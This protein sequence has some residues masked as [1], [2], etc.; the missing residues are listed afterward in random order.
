MT[1]T[2]NQKRVLGI[3]GSPRRGGNTEIIVDE[4]LSGAAQAGAVVEKIIL[5]ELNIGPCRA[6]DSCYTIRKCV[7]HDDMV[8]L[9]EKMQLS[10]VWVLGT[11]VY[12]MGPTAQFKT[13]LDRWY[14]AD[15]GHIV[16]FKGKRAILAIS[17]EDRKKATAHHTIGM[18]TGALNWLKVELLATVLAPGVRAKGAVK[19]CSDILTTARNA[20]REALSVKGE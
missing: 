18:L 11:P 8:S 15:H 4:V 7:Q 9:L 13:F 19:E 20:G 12:Y 10:E 14:G 2:S 5:N 16:T 6:C 3:V 1:E 17:M